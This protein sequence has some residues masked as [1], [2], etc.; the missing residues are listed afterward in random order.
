MVG[1]KALVIALNKLLNSKDTDHPRIHAM[2]MRLVMHD[3]AT[4]MPALMAYLN[5]GRDVGKAVVEP[6]VQFPYDRGGK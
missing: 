5:K 1:D 6:E 4:W 3:K 2:Y